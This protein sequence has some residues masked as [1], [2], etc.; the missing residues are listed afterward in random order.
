[1][2]APIAERANPRDLPGGL[3]VACGLLVAIG[4]LSFVAGLL[5][6]PATAWRAY[7][8]NF[9]Y[10]AGLAQGGLVVACA[11]VIVGA[12]WAG[13]VRHVAAGLAAWAPVTFV[14]CAIGFFGREYVFENWIHGAPPPKEHWLTAGRVYITD[15][16]ILGVLALLSLSFL[17]TSFRPAMHGVAERVTRAKS[18]FEGWTRDWQGDE[19]ERQASADKLKRLAPIIALTYAFGYGVLGTDQVMSLTPTWFSNIF[20]WYFAWGGFLC[21]I[22]ATALLCVL[23]RR[24][25]E[26]ANEITKPRMHDLGKM[27][28]AFSIFWMYLF[29]SQYIVIWYGNLPEETQFFQLRLGSQFLQDTWTFQ[30]V[31]LEEPYVKLSL[32]AWIGCWWVPFWVLLGQVPKQTPKI[33]GSVAAVLLLGF[34][35]ER[36]ALVWPSLLPENDT[37]WRQPLAIGIALGFL[38]AFAAVQLVFTRVFPTLPL[39]SRD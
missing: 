35:L 7:H 19:A 2:N 27:L 5:T 39:P 13:P 29:F 16:T 14:L 31:R 10:W 38:G 9:L 20:P 3:M 37:Q 24:T 33:L 30:S 12:R 4:V 8:V 11:L 26:W 17:R 25:P 21:G 15:L 34:W 1:V 18:L 23:L 32:A 36:N 22:A 28:F 6:D